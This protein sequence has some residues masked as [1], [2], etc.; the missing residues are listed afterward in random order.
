MLGKLNT[1][2]EKNETGSLTYTYT[3]KLN[4]NGLSNKSKTW[5]FKSPGRKHRIKSS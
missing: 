3:Q 4:R 5:N 2:M 1:H